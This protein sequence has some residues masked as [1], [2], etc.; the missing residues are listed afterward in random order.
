M[1]TYPEA[2]GY[3]KSAPE[4]SEKA[5]HEIASD[6]FTLRMKALE[7]FKR[8]MKLTSNEVAVVLD[9]DPIAVQPRVSEL[10]T[11]GSIRPSGQKRRNHRTNK[12]A[13]VWELTPVED[14]FD[15]PKKRPKRR[16]RAELESAVAVLVDRLRQIH[17]CVGKF[18]PEDGRI[19]CEIPVELFDAIQADIDEVGVAR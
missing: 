10:Y 11:T 17:S 18:S 19:A 3:R 7:L 4:T 8:G 5:A 2:P 14:L 1:S 9:R 12:D 6:A 15:P 13:T 16:T